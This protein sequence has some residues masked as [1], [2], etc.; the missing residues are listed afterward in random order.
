MSL[1]SHRGDLESE[2]SK[3]IRSVGIDIGSTTTQI[4]FSKLKLGYIEGTN[5]LDVVNREITYLSDVFM[6]PFKGSY[7]I[8]VK[9]LSSILNRI[10]EDAGFALGEVDTGAIIITGEAAR[11]RNS[12]K[13]IDLFANQ[14]G[15]FVCAI[16]GPNY[17]AALAAHGSGSLK[18]SDRRKITV[19]NVDIGGGTSKIAVLRN[20][21]VVDTA[22]L[23]V[24]ARC[25]VLDEKGR[26]TRFNNPGEIIARATDVSLRLGEKMPETDQRRMACAMANCLFEV[27]RRCQISD[28]TKQLMITPQ[29]NYKGTI[30]R[31]VFSGG[32]AEYIYGYED[33]DFG[34]L[35]RILGGEIRI[36]IRDLEACLSEP[37]ERIRATV[38]GVSQYTLQVSGTTNFV[39]DLSLLPLR[40]L[41]IVAPS[42]AVRGVPKESVEK[43]IKRSL[44]MHD[45]S[46]GEDY[47]ALMF[48]RSVIDQPS[49]ET[50]KTLAGAIISTLE[51]TIKN[52]K[53]IV[54]VFEADIGRGMGRVIKEEISPKINL[55]SIDEIVLHGFN[56]V[57]IG[58]PTGERGLIPVVIKSLV[59]PT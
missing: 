5:K 20:G 27:M 11:R 52:R 42:F 55:V 22:S 38:I 29:L 36:G 33:R 19:M 41:P 2:S 53:T 34:D 30:N 43:A 49:Y 12:R 58:K 31:I 4:V 32:V 7:S 51:N 59:F 21:Q 25:I 44:E 24:G 48:S 16:A 15:K 23:C 57:D 28:L 37:K 47:V 17:E 56:Y 6:T 35:G 50:M 3:S 9:R 40:N 54:I 14:M 45:I 39:S 8:V 10:Y 1:S 18:L 46:E 13:I 26:L